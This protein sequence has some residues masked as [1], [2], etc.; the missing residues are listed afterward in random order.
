MQQPDATWWQAVDVEGAEGFY[1]V[2]A[3]LYVDLADLQWRLEYWG[4]TGVDAPAQPFVAD[5]SGY[6]PYEPYKLNETDRDMA[7]QTAATL[8]FIDDLFVEMSEYNPEMPEGGRRAV[9]TDPNNLV[10]GRRVMEMATALRAVICEWLQKQKEQVEIEDVFSSNEIDAELNEE[11]RALYDNLP[12]RARNE[13]DENH[14]PEK[15]DNKYTETG[16]FRL[17]DALIDSI[18]N[19]ERR[20]T[21]E[22]T[23]I[24]VDLVVRLFHLFFYQYDMEG[25]LLNIRGSAEYGGRKARLLGTE[26]DAWKTIAVSYR[27]NEKSEKY[28]IAFDTRE[29][30]M[31]KNSAFMMAPNVSANPNNPLAIEARKEKR[32]RWLAEVGGRPLHKEL[33]PTEDQQ[34]DGA[35]F[36]FGPDQTLEQMREQQQ[37]IVQEQDVAKEVLV[38]ARRTNLART[39]AERVRLVQ[40]EEEKRKEEEEE[41]RKAMGLSDYKLIMRGWAGRVKDRQLPPPTAK[42]WTWDD[43]KKGVP[44]PQMAHVRREAEAIFQA[45]ALEEDRKGLQ[46]YKQRKQDLAEERAAAATR[47]ETRAKQRGK[48]VKESNLSEAKSRV[49]YNQYAIFDWL[50]KDK[51]RLKQKVEAEGCASAWEYRYRNSKMLKEFRN[52]I[53]RQ[54]WERHYGRPKPTYKELFP[55]KTQNYFKNATARNEEV[56]DWMRGRIVRPLVRDID[57][58]GNYYYHAAEDGNQRDMTQATNLRCQTHR[59][60]YTNF[61]LS[62]GRNQPRDPRLTYLFTNGRT[63]GA[64]IERMQLQYEQFMSDERRHLLDVL[65]AC[66]PKPSRDDLERCYQLDKDSFALCP[67]EEEEREVET[68]APRAS[69][70][71]AKAR[72]WYE[73][74]CKR[75]EAEYSV[76]IV[77][78][79]NNKGVNKSAPWEDPR[80]VDDASAKDWVDDVRASYLERV[81]DPL[82]GGEKTRALGII[83]WKKQFAE[84]HANLFAVNGGRPCKYG[85]MP[86]YDPND[87]SNGYWPAIKRW[88]EFERE[89]SVLNQIDGKLADKKTDNPVFNQF[90]K[91]KGHM[92]LTFKNYDTKNPKNDPLVTSTQ[93]EQGI[94]KL[95]LKEFQA[96]AE[97]KI[98]EIVDGEPIVK[99][100]VDPDYENDEWI[101]PQH[102][103]VWFDTHGDHFRYW[104][105]RQDANLIYK[106]TPQKGM[107]AQIADARTSKVSDVFFKRMQ[108]FII[109]FQ[110]DLLVCFPDAENWGDAA[111]P[112]FNDIMDFICWFMNNA[113]VEWEK[114]QQAGM[115]EKTFDKLCQFA[116][117]PAYS[118]WKP[119]PKTVY[120]KGENKEER[121]LDEYDLWDRIG[122]AFKR[123]WRSIFFVKKALDYAVYNQSSVLYAPPPHRTEEAA[124]ILAKWRSITEE[125]SGA[126]PGPGSGPGGGGGGGGSGGGGKGGGSGDPDP[127]PDPDDDDEREGEGEEDPM[128]ADDPR[129]DAVRN[130]TR[131]LLERDPGV[132]LRG[133]NVVGRDM[134]AALR[135]QYPD[136]ELVNNDAE[137][138]AMRAVVDAE[139]HVAG[140]PLD[141]LLLAVRAVVDAAAET[142]GEDA[143]DGMK[144][145]VVARL[146]D[147][148]FNPALER[149]DE[150]KEVYA[151]LFESAVA[152]RPLRDEARSKIDEAKELLARAKETL[153]D[154]MFM[155]LSS[156]EAQV[157]QAAVTLEANNSINV[158]QHVL[159]G[160]NGAIAIIDRWVKTLLVPEEPEPEPDP[161][162]REKRDGSL[163]RA[164]AREMNDVL[165]AIK[166]EPIDDEPRP[167]VAALGKWD[168]YYPDDGEL[169][170][171]WWSS[172]YNATWGQWK[173]IFETILAHPDPG[174][175]I[176]HAPGSSMDSNRHDAFIKLLAEY[177][178][179]L[180]LIA[181]NVGEYVRA[182]Q[183]AIEALEKA[184]EDSDCIVGHLFYENAYLDPVRVRRWKDQLT[185][186]RHKLGYYRQLVRPDVFGLQGANCWYNFEERHLLRAEARLEVEARLQREKIERGE[187]P[188]V[189]SRDQVNEQVRDAFQGAQA[190]QFTLEK[191]QA[192]AEAREKKQDQ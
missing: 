128:L 114:D 102:A 3:K 19:A 182:S 45:K 76:T 62:M 187:D 137:R 49:F 107:Y 123:L 174:L 28:E 42:P 14:A 148:G 83:A 180:K 75:Q 48:G 37:E 127:D 98:M 13:I 192:A 5:D 183:E 168:G 10:E 173:Q 121:F 156:L 163:H 67:T 85:T 31:K 40:E 191:L 125:P 57:S 60:M 134:H 22:V 175:A 133:I 93:D 34:C 6:E 23:Q 171:A 91:D 153:G 139:L 33:E 158:V 72:Y 130:V 108:P 12:P 73:R 97:E 179:R 120:K 185:R 71:G 90:W 166:G 92:P 100:Q 190:V 124:A 181:V 86:K 52:T 65:R 99:S 96:H 117:V 115:E 188:N 68:Q 161:E 122:K 162:P 178:P 113:Y 131:G 136:L 21:Q 118:T 47:D 105:N 44:G 38:N 61:Q 15:Y 26:D 41:K 18:K 88:M 157:K 170:L 95:I 24:E 25:N 46:K 160:L 4:G 9:H 84:D 20:K 116:C 138:D 147:Q 164:S 159:N 78:K 70:K 169:G 167:P 165:N 110:S 8:K 104:V 63:T 152:L 30:V 17:V 106:T 1:L 176:L 11:A 172:P 64:D 32:D 186:N 141:D 56:K 51:P 101:G 54:L 143:A 58:D 154:A 189:P 80:G 177:L 59:H 150:R 74:P 112:G 87:A 81:N 43:L 144:G 89:L 109:P 36:L 16:F 66:G 146:K 2:F 79:D 55:E 77:D 140:V 151:A 129:W 142:P 103:N 82:F 39:E 53:A 119:P 132:W 50:N 69:G 149:W 7:R 94:L 145:A 29:Y 155:E 184:L 135:E 27:Y 35:Q 126:P 111:F